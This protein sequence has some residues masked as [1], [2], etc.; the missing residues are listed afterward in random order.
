MPSNYSTQYEQEKSQPK[1]KQYDNKIQEKKLTN[2]NMS[3]SK[4]KKAQKNS[5]SNINQRNYE[6]VQYEREKK[7]NKQN[8]DYDYYDKL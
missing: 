5:T 7:S 2:D 8:I 6:S 1:E 3:P 4:S